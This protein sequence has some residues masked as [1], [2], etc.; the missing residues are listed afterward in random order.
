VAGRPGAAALFALCAAAVLASHLLQAPYGFNIRD[1]GFLWYG[2]QRVLAGEVPM[3]DFDAYDPGRYYW[4]AAVMGLLGDDG[5]SSLRIAIS[6]F[7]VAGLALALWLVVRE[8]R[9]PDVIFW[10]LATA[11]LLAWMVPRHKLF[12][13]TLSI[14]LVAALAALVRRPDARF[15]F[16]AGLAVGA[17]AVFGRN[18]GVYGVV[19]SLLAMG[20]IAMGGARPPGMARNVVLWA[21]GIAVGY[22]PMLLLA[23]FVPGFFAAVVESV[24]FLFEVEATNLPLPV[25]WPWT[26]PFGRLGML[27]G[28]R[29][30]LVGL[31]F[32]AIVV[33]AAAAV[34]WVF[35]RRVRGAATP[36]VLVACACMAVP[37]AHYAYS[38]ADIGHLAHGIFPA[39]IGVLALL[40]ARPRAIRWP[41]AALL[42]AA[43]LAVTL[44]LQPGWRCRVIGECVQMAVGKDRLTIDP[45][46]AEALSI[47]K[48]L[49]DRYAAQPGRT[50]YVA[51][52][53]TGA[54]AALSKR[55]PVWEVYPLFPRGPAFEDAEIERLRRADPV[56]AVIYDHP[57]DG[58]EDLRFR[59]TH[60]RIERYVRET[61][62]PVEAHPGGPAVQV[63]VKR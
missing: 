6:L 60:P 24:R 35:T 52:L 16:V 59:N 31:F 61:M 43:T 18:H 63:Y 2:V 20:F 13:V 32:I 26:V 3:R 22:A 5:I 62:R 12:D 1:E 10:A 49:H 46:P 39:L 25:P 45:V 38:R 42:C 33:F 37:Y 8:E 48:Q 55:A 40:A 15:H 30:A 44:P 4:S 11:T 17:A 34:A 58:R 21:I 19:G 9:A 14:A 47:M 23:L 50:F 7:Q 27:Q 36:P 57:L 28:A 53:W 51:P 56:L 29:E 41:I 54:Y